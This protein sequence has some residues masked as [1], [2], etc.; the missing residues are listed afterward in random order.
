MISFRTLVYVFAFGLIAL[1]TIGRSQEEPRRPEN[2]ADGA[3]SQQAEQP[4]ADLLPA[5]EGI[6]AAIRDL[7]REES[8]EERNRAANQVAQDVE[9]QT[10]MAQ[11]AMEM[12]LAS[13]AAAL[14][15]LVGL[16]LIW[17]TLHY[18][19]KAAL[20][21][22]GMLSEAKAA[23]LEAKAANSIMAEQRRAWV[24]IDNFVP[25][26]VKSDSQRN[27]DFEIALEVVPE[28]INKGDRPASLVG[29]SVGHR[30]VRNGQIPTG[31]IDI[32]SEPDDNHGIFGTD[33]KRTTPVARIIDEEVDLF[34]GQEGYL[35]VVSACRYRDPSGGELWNTSAQAQ[36][37][38]T[39]YRFD[40]NGNISDYR[41]IAV[42]VGPHNSAT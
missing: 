28:I 33:Q 29:F 42:F 16:V 17:R 2:A 6:E 4:V 14:F 19:K 10:E 27:V 20:S 11:W 24:C 38:T 9:A 12:A 25:Q 7:V 30:F 18:T 41:Y 1:P 13:M 32:K 31:E 22:D 3:T 21:A 26:I 34:H 37:R 15:T 39:G 40:G 23:T 5:L 36:I 8:E 35:E